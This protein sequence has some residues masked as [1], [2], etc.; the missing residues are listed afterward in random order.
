MEKFLA[1]SLLAG[2]HAD[3]HSK[4]GLNALALYVLKILKKGNPIVPAI[5]HVSIERLDRMAWD[6]TF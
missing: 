2:N 4:I 5:R 3:F 1:P 6:C